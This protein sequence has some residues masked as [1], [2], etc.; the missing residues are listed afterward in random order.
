M[1]THISLR[2]AAS[3]SEAREAARA[4]GQAA[5]MPAVEIERCANAISELCHN[6]LRYG[7]DGSV[8]VRRITRGGVHGVEA[9]VSDRGPGIEDAAAALG[10]RPSEFGGLGIGLGAAVRLCHELDLDTRLGEGTLVIPRRF[11]T[12][13]QRLPEVGIVGRPHSDGPPSGDEARVWRLSDGFLLAVA[14]GLGHGA[15]AHEGA[16]ALVT[17]VG[18][19]VHEGL[20]EMIVAA[21]GAAKGTRGGAL[22]VVRMQGRELQVCGVGNIIVRLYAGGRMRGVSAHAGTLTGRRLPMALRP[23]TFE[24]GP[25]TRLLVCTDGIRSRNLGDETLMGY[26]H[27]VAAA[28]GVLQR[29]WRGTDDA[30]VAVAW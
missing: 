1:V 21:N 30:L 20:P 9:R 29:H 26:S 6:A 12:R 18:S 3:V 25:G 4:V 15:A 19:A 22:T 23:R 7:R 27:P 17:A 14:D 8:S 24:V 13:A 2:D 28:S 5:G 11:A 10:G 16:Q